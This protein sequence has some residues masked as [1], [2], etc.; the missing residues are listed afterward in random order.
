MSR[1]RRFQILC[2]LFLIMK[3]PVFGQ[4]T[5]D[6]LTAKPMKLITPEY[7]KKGDT[8]AIVAPA[9]ILKNKEAVVQKAK[10]LAESWGLNVVIGKNTFNQGNHFAG[11]DNERAA[12]FQKALD[13]PNVKAIWCARGGYGSVRIYLPVFDPQCAFNELGCHSDKTGNHEPEYG[14]RP[15]N[16]DRNSHAGNIANANRARNRRG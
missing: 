14:P 13:A 12:D 15:P 5:Q 9:G 11:T 8:I 3:I 2:L 6:S 16:R 4:H 1:I 10:E 7:L